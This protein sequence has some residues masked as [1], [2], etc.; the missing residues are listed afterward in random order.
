M[1][2]PP[3]F[4]LDL[5]LRRSDMRWKTG[6]LFLLLVTCYPLYRFVGLV[7]LGDSAITAAYLGPLSHRIAYLGIILHL[8]QNALENCELYISHY[9][10]HSEKFVQKGL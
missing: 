8:H 1:K 5:E 9:L 2:T 3:S 4:A 7:F 10:I 6:N